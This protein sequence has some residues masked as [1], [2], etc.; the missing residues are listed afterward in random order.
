MAKEPARGKSLTP[1]RPLPPTQKIPKTD[2]LTTFP[3]LGFARYEGEWQY[4]LFDG[5]GSMH[6]ANGDVY[7]GEWLDG[8]RDGLGTMS[9]ADTGKEYRGI[10]ERDICQV[11][12]D[13]Q[14]ELGFSTEIPPPPIFVSKPGEPS[15]SA[16][17]TTTTTTM[18]SPAFQSTI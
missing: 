3:F 12:F 17:S 4:D 2:K 10:W 15:T 16:M 13:E 7:A 5:Y 8:L 1:V 18:T 6:Y 14:G 11:T 9:E